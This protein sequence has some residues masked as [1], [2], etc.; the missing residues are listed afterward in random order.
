MVIK[1]QPYGIAPDGIMADIYTLV[2]S[3]GF[4]V[5]ITNYG[6][7]VTAIKT[8]DRYGDWGDIVLGYDTLEEYIRHS[9]YF[10]CIVGRFANRIARGRFTLDGVKYILAQNDGENHLH[11]GLKGFDK[12]VWKVETSMN[13]DGPSLTL[14]HRSPDGE[15][16]YPGNLDV[17]VT[18]SLT[19]ANEL[20]IDYEAVTDRATVLNLT[21]HSYFNLAGAEAG[22]IL[23]H[24]LTINAD[25]F[26]PIDGTLI[27]TGELSPVAGTPLDFTRPRIIG[28]RID[29]DNDQLKFGLGYDHNWVLMPSEKS[30]KFA[31]RVFEPGSGRV[32]EVFTTEP[33]MQFYSGNFLD[34]TFIGKMGKVYNKRDGFCLETQHFPDSSNKPQFPSTVLRPG[35]RYTQTTVFRFSVK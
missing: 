21:N 17:T 31:A 24:E 3:H 26:T 10:G 1:K 35:E 6:G 27:P 20:C 14:T 5:C 16:G 23:G 15:E 25:T 34:G 30:L 32:M 29:N 13:A 28:D 12:A 7:I 4:E 2:N 8:P 9:P 33:G 22:N 19:G 11:G 18:Y